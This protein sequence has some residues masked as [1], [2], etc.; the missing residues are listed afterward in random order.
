MKTRFYSEKYNDEVYEIIEKIKNKDKRFSLLG[1]GTE[2]HSVIQFTP[3]IAVKVYEVVEN[4]EFISYY[5]ILNKYTDIYNFNLNGYAEIIATIK[6]SSR[7]YILQEY[8]KIGKI[9]DKRTFLS[10]LKNIMITNL[11]FDIYDLHKQN[12]GLNS[13]GELVIIDWGHFEGNTRRKLNDKDKFFE[14]LTHPS[15]EW[16]SNEMRKYDED[17]DKI[18]EEVIKE[19]I[20]C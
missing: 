10:F 19:R 8:V 1:M 17:Y 20:G 13:K 5:K 12:V 2:V 7:F 11:F 4:V 6:T 3:N 15:M 9:G 14:I 16:I 18:Y